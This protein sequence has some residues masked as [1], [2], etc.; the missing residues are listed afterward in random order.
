[1][2]AWA[3]C[4]LTDYVIP[5]EVTLFDY[6]VFANNKTIR[7]LTFPALDFKTY[8]YTDYFYGCDNLEYFY[9]EGTTADHHCLMMWRNCL[10]AVTK[11][12]PADYAVPGGYGITQVFYEIVRHNSTVERFALPDDITFPADA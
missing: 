7:S 4:G 11:I 6:T 2:V 10:F 12:L 5:P 8:W 1:M 9:G 3:G